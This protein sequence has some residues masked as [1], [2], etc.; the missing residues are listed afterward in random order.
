VKEAKRRRPVKRVRNLPSC[1]NRRAGGCCAKSFDD[2][3]GEVYQRSVAEIMINARS[4][5]VTSRDDTLVL[6]FA[7]ALAQLRSVLRPTLD[8]SVSPLR[9][10][11]R[12]TLAT[13]FAVSHRSTLRPPFGLGDSVEVIV[14][15]PSPDVMDLSVPQW[16]ISPAHMADVLWLWLSLNPRRPFTHS[17]SC[18]PPSPYKPRR[19]ARPPGTPSTCPS[20]T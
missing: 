17:P 3:K 16:S 6:S 18:R 10:Q 2:G 11:V 5:K 9:I 19:P 15:H 13:C 7:I 1:W 8:S 20:P 14:L 12:H 4:G